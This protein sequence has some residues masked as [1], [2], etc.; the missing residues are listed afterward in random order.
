MNYE[1]LIPL[2]RILNSLELRRTGEFFKRL[3]TYI[4][5]RLLVK[6]NKFW[7]LVDQAELGGAGRIRT[8][9]PLLAKQMFSL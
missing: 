4:K 3:N 5:Y 9:D 1:R 2:F 8:D 6:L 7:G